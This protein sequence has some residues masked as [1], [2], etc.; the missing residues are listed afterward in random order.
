[1]SQQTPIAKKDYSP[2]G[3]QQQ[4]AVPKPI[5]QPDDQAI[6]SAGNQA[7]KEAVEQLHPKDLARNLDPNQPAA[8]PAKA[9]KPH[10]LQGMPLVKCQILLREQIQNNH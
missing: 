3:N 4:P 2:T 9:M 6:S 5:A 7:I 8:H 10:H 1:M